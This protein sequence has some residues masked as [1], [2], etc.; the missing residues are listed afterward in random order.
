MFYTSS[1][2]IEEKTSVKTWVTTPTYTTATNNGVLNLNSTSATVHFITGNQ[3]G[4]S[5]ILPNAQ[6]MSLGTNIEI[7]NRTSSAI[8]VKYQDGTLLGVLDAEAVSSLI[9]QDNASTNGMFSPFT[10]E[11]AQAA[12]ILNYNLQQQTAFSTTSTTDTQITSFSITPASGEYF[13]SFNSSNISS[14]NNAEC[15]CSIYKAGSQVLG[16]ERTARSTA[17]N[18]VLQLSTQGVASFNGTESLT[19]AVRVTAGTLTVNNRSVVMLRLGGI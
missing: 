12:G 9:L 5:I 13:I 17:S 7:Y 11:I 2:T 16:T 6:T 14:L 10:V 4:F 1:A 19:V 3:T 18:F 15:T 8:L